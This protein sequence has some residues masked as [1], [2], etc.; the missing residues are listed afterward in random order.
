MLKLRGMVKEET[1]GIVASK[2][3]TISAPRLMRQHS[4]VVAAVITTARNPVKRVSAVAV[5]VEFIRLRCCHHSLR[6][7]ETRSTN[8][9]ALQAYLNKSYQLQLSHC[10]M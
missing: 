2:V 8:E 4:P 1:R 7:L 10:E 9:V 6:N 3:S 5:A